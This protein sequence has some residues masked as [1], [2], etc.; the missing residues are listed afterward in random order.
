[1]TNAEISFIPLTEEHFSLL[2][3][4]F[5]KPHVQAFY[6]LRTWTNEDVRQKL[7]PYIQGVGDMKCYIIFVDKKPMGYLQCYPVKKHPW[8]NQNLPDEIV[9]DSVG[10]DLFIGEEESIGKGLGSQFLNA[11]LRKHIWP[12]YRYCL[13]DPDIR[14]EASLRLFKKCGFKE[15][16]LIS[17]T[18]ALKRIITLQLFIK[19]RE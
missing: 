12:H 19:K 18:D 16:Q 4:W 7:P 5:N 2:R 3:T 14:N 15:Y 6:S 1:M 11:F 8:D 13:A 10:L 9:Q 17:S